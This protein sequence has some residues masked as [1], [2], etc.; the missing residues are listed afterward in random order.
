MRTN[1]LEDGLYE[2]LID[3]ETKKDIQHKKY[4][5]K[6]IIDKSELSNVVS[7][8]Y[9]KIIR[10]TL[11]H[12]EKKEEKINFIKK[13]NNTIGIEDFELS[14]KG[15]EE[16]LAVHNDERSFGNLIK[17]RPKT[18]IAH[19]TLFTGSSTT[20]LESELSR[21]IRTADQVDLLV[22]F[23]KFSGLRLIYND[24]VEFTKKNKLRVITTS[25]MGASDYKAI[26]EL[27]KLPNTQ[28]KIS[29]D[30]KRTR[31]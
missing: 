26:L 7:I 11:S 4:K 16:L 31:L 25:Y 27:A 8:A 29:Y 2:R 23:I 21:E 15:Y 20:T 6:R 12:I 1:K 24:L 13:L 10:E 28:V 17:Y 30:T 18:S 22:S 14:Q 19:S 5:G 9:Q 3:S